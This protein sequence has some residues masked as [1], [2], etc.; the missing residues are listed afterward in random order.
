VRRPSPFDW[1]A[2]ALLAAAAAWVAAG[3]RHYSYDD[4]FITFRMAANAASGHG[5]VYNPGEW[6]LGSTAALY[7]LLLAALGRVAGPGQI[8]S[9]AGWISVA[10]VLATGLLLYVLFRGRGAVREAAGGADPVVPADARAAGLAAGLVYVTSPMIFVTFGGEMP[11][12]LAVATAACL[13]L[14][15][16]RSQVAAALGAVAALVRPDGVLVL[17][18]VL[19]ATLLRRRRLPWRELAVAASIL[20]P[21][22]LL[23][24]H[25]YGTPLPSTLAAKLAQRDSGLWS[26]FGQGLR[27]WLVLFL[28]ND[29][30]P[31]LGFAPVVPPTLWLWTAIGLVAVWRHRRL[32]PLLAWVVLFV[33]AYSAMRVPFYHWYAAPAALALAA[34]AG[35]GLA[36]AAAWLARVAARSR[37]D[38]R[39]VR[40]LAAVLPV[41]AALAI[42]W[43]PL[44]ALP[45]TSALN[46]NVRLYIE[47][48]RWIADATPPGSRVGYYEIGYIGFHGRRPMIDA[49]GLIDPAIA[50][51]VAAH[52]W[53]RAFRQARPEY[54]LEKPGAGL[55]TFLAEPWFTAE[56]RL[57]RELRV[58]GEALR[59]HRRIAGR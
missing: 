10:A 42:G 53:A 29:R 26:T 58:G 21:F 49:L 15:R 35:A 7:G 38:G 5:F 27:D 13:A 31:N 37:V 12:L 57:E 39:R 11:V 20:V 25:A 34:C 41:A 33:A 52:D 19:A 36:E 56:Y 18:V 3:N 4:A 45:R 50:P 46:D 51:A 55:N 43:R 17:G 8:P 28:W 59:V 40:A 47:A 9:V 23:A 2:A 14:D 16:D 32:W 54:I 30:G 6:H 44:R 24:W 1:T 48:G 22:A